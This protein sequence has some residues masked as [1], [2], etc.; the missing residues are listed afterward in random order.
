MM[1]ADCA[2]DTGQ[3]GVADVEYLVANGAIVTRKLR[4][5]GMLIDVHPGTYEVK[6]D[7]PNTRLG[8]VSESGTIVTSG[9]LYVG[10][11]C[12]PFSS[13]D[14]WMGFVNKTNYLEN[15]GDKMFN[16]STGGD[17]EFSVGIELNEVCNIYKP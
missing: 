8:D 3:I 9:K 14:A 12:Y 15:G 4:R 1:I 13:D 11:M 2:V 7:I 17:G 6:L 16:V 10:D 5:W